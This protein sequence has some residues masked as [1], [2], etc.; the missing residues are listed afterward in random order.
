M[1]EN[2]NLLIVSFFILVI[3]YS[4]SSA[5]GYTQRFTVSPGDS[6]TLSFDLA[7][8]D[9]IRFWIAVNGGANDDVNITIRDPHGIINEGRVDRE[10]QDDLYA[11]F[12]GTYA[13]EFDNS[14]SLI[15]SKQVEFSYEIIKKP[16]ETTSYAASGLPGG[17]EW[18]II[19]VPIIIGIGVGVG[20]LLRKKKQAI[21]RNSSVQ[22]NISK[23][24][25]PIEKKQDEKALDILKGRLARGEVTKEEYDR[26]KK[27]FT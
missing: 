19:I 23:E 25:D 22:E 13:F 6:Y 26:L 27:E 18:L 11:D 21:V 9:R 10:F 3:L 12:S 20:L 15:S 1:K 17:M 14:F 16:S 8:G 5:F 24:K 7:Q 2:F 4:Q